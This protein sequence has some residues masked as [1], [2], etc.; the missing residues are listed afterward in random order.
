MNKLSKNRCF[1]ECVENSVKNNWELFALC[2]YKG[3]QYRYKDVA[4]EIAKLHILFSESGIEKG[5]RIAICGRN[6]AN[7]GIAFFASL[8]YG[9]VVVPILNEFKPD[10]VHHIVEH[11]EA[12]ILFVGDV[13]K[14]TLNVDKMPNLKAMINIPDFSLAMSR[15]EKIEETQSNL[16]KLFVEKYPYH[17]FPINA[18]SIP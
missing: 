17:V 8:T 6:S 7:W 12:K 2:D 11:S 1:N 14:P 18:F 13:V 3:K 9:S 10:Q 4:A 16:E 5:D 15:E